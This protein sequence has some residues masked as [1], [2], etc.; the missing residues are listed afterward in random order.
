MYNEQGKEQQ[1]V[2]ETERNSQGGNLK[3]K[4]SGNM[5]AKR[6]ESFVE[7]IIVNNIM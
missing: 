2:K 3:I 6:G 7:E 5:Q 1:F 4:K